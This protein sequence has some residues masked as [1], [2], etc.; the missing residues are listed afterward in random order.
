MN[1]K[2]KRQ[3]ESKNCCRVWRTPILIRIIIKVSEMEQEMKWLVPGRL[4]YK[5]KRQQ[6]RVKIVAEFGGLLIRIIIKVAE[7][8]KEMKWLVPGVVGGWEI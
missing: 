3:Q 8:E 6:E 5:V 1:Y 4:N 2:V 7:M